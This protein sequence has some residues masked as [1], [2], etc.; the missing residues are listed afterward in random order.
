MLGRLGA[1]LVALHV[2]DDNFVQPQP[3]T[4]P[5][6]HV[7]SG[8]VPLALLALAMWAYPRLRPGLRGLLALVLV[9]PALLSG[10]EAVHYGPAVG[11]SG[12]DVTGLLAA[13]AAP[14]FLG[15]GVVTLWR[16]RR[17]VDALHRRYPRRALK[18][19]IAVALAP[20]IAIPISIAYVGSHAARTEVPA[21]QLGAAYEDVTLETSD[22]LELEGWYVPSR[23][24]AA[25]IA[26]PGRTGNR[27]HA[28]MLARNGYGVLL[29]D[30]RGEGRSEG[31]PNAWGWDFNKDIKAGIAFLK[32]RKD[33]DPG[34]IGGLGLSV[35]GEM[36]LQT[37]AETTD[38]AAV[39]S[40]GAG[41]RT[42]AEE[43][44]DA[45]GLNKVP[46]TLSYLARDAA[47]A[48]FSNQLPP[49]HLEELI[50]KIAPRPILLI[51]AGSREV[52][53]LNPRYYRAAGE[54][55]RI[56][57]VPSGGHT[58]GIDTRPGEYERR[59]VA[60]FDAALGG[61]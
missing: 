49:A 56:W 51:H 18:A 22:G 33:V 23:N 44:S 26:F 41:A 60:F 53:R 57:E 14:L 50:P 6:D 61:N 19:A 35:G 17:V 28:R 58:D 12:D 11:L 36:L 42:L 32:R 39:V 54:P 37:A 13:S 55:K 31:D 52:G 24:G 34:R 8:L 15:L 10:A 30:R 20:L 38:L 9:L 3:G 27:K 45:K 2:V 29:F 21:A 46:L 16:S 7:V 5:A 40:E 48:V 47:N 1:G 59:V 4:G 43:S 25:V